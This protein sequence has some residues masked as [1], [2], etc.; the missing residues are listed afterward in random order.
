M[1]NCRILSSGEFNTYLNNESN[2]SSVCFAVLLNQ[3]LSLKN[4]DCAI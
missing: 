4:Y 3:T 2:N 1:M